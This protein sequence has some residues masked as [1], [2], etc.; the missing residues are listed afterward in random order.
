MSLLR[1][2]SLT[3]LASAQILV[4]EIAAISE[5]A[6]VL[7]ARQIDAIGDGVVVEIAIVP[8]SNTELERL[9]D[10]PGKEE[11]VRRVRTRQPSIQHWVSVHPSGC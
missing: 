7:I 2:W 8:R 5:K 10:K 4:S 3:A 11:A 1:I 9:D 6:S